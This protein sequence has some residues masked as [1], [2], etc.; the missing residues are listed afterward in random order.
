MAELASRAADRAG[1]AVDT[2]VVYDPISVRDAV[3]QLV[4]RTAA[5][6]VLGTHRRTRPMR[7]L[8][9]SHAARAVHE[10]EVP[11]LVVPQDAGS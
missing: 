3:V 11:A 7:A 9:G 5:L 8:H 4:D 2:R 10:V 6:L 1:I